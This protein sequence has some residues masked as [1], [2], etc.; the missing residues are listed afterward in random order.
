MIILE[1]LLIN[2]SIMKTECFI[3]CMVAIMLCSCDP[4]LVPNDFPLQDFNSYAPYQEGQIVKF[5]SEEGSIEYQVATVEESYNRGRIDCK[6]GKESVVKMV[7]FESSIDT[8][9]LWLYSMDRAL[10][11]VVLQSNN[12]YRLNAEYIVDYSESEDIWEKSYDET[13]IFKEFASECTLLQNGKPAAK[14]KKNVGVL[15]FGTSE[16]NR[17]WQLVDK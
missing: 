17:I 7:I 9:Q 10:F 11:Q 8:M 3:M 12:P 4:Y 15:W 5:E 6:C 16:G 13:K 14:I 2:D 1:K